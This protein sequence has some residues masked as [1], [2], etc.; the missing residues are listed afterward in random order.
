M[1]K[2]VTDTQA[3][4]KYFEGKKVIND[5]IHTIFKMSE[6]GEA[7]IIVPAPVIFEI[8]I[9]NQK[10]RTPVSL[11]TLEYVFSV[12]DCLIEKSLDFNIIKTAFDINDI[13]ELHDRLIAGAARYLN[14]PLLT[15]DPLMI[16]SQ[17]VKTL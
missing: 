2:Y 8:G 16:Q 3:I 15:N 10:G 9:L 17:F 5:K 11:K 1:N 13:P 12:T 7:L 14:I 6:F 4:V